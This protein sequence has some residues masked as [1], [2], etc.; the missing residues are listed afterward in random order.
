MTF[1]DAVAWWYG[2]I[3]FEARAADPADLKLERMRALLKCVGDPHD[4]L[5]IVHVAGT[6]GKGS[7]CALVE[8]AARAAGYR[9]GLFTSPHLEDVRERIQVDR[10][11]VMPGELAALISEIAP[12]VARLDAAGPTAGATFFEIT[13]AAGLLHFVRR[14]AELVLLEVGLGGRF[15]STNVCRPLVTAITSIGLDHTAQLGATAELIAAQKAGILKRGVPAVVGPLDPGPAAVVARIAAEV[16][17]PVTPS[18][19]RPVPPVGLPGGHQR[20]NAAVAGGIIDHLRRAG[21]AI[22]DAAVTR[23]FATVAWPARV[24]LVRTH[25]AVVLDSAHNAPSA[26]ALVATLSEVVPGALERKNCHLIF[27]VAADKPVREMVVQFAKQF[28]H[29]HLTRFAAN[30]RSVAPADLA[31]LVTELV[32]GVTVTT[33]ATAAEA[34]HAARAQVPP[35]GLVCVAGSMFLAGELGAIVRLADANLR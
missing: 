10:D 12:A 33:H 5:R 2:R 7:T 17:A 16:G 8:A 27:A 15:D 3:N 20:Q 18:A 21:F 31:R 1:A 22:P 13:T 11:P 24:E 9:V 35:D 25:P 19:G 6:K 34:Y 28:G 14:R 30:A 26:A 4:R 23:G 29:F 32:P